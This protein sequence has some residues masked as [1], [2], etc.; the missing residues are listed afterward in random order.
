MAQRATQL[1]QHIQKMVTILRP[2][3][4]TR[5]TFMIQLSLQPCK[6]TGPM[7]LCSLPLMRSIEV[8]NHML[9]KHNSYLRLFSSKKRKWLKMEY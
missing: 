3:K 4:P 2:T 1:D 8:L 7:A 9:C 5:P 6:C